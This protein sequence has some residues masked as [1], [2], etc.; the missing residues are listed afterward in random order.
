MT[1][2]RLF[3]LKQQGHRTL[4]EY[5]SHFT[6]MALEISMAT[7]E[8]LIS[9]L[10]HGLCKGDFFR[11]FKNSSVNCDDLLGRAQRYIN[12]KEAQNAK[13]E[14]LRWA[15][16]PRERKKNSMNLQ[17]GSQ[18]PSYI[19]L[20]IYKEKVIQILKENWMLQWSCG[21]ATSPHN[22]PS[23][24]F[25]CFSQEVWTHDEDM[26]EVEPRD[27]AG[28]DHPR[29]R[30]SLNPEDAPPPKKTSEKDAKNESTKGGSD[31]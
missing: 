9:V 7:L 15:H 31:S 30:P 27:R 21:H 18:F 1:P 5:I 16:L 2:L 14:E 8:V 20:K 26:L 23:A 10:S 13:R 24:F 25:V 4:R 17:E 6:N 22:T 11:L 29:I 3:S 12:V 28:C 19:P